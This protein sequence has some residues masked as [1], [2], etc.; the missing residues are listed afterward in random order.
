[1][2]VHRG[3]VVLALAALCLCPG[4]VVSVDAGP[5]TPADPSATAT[6]PAVAP[7]APETARASGAGDAVG[8]APETDTTVVDIEVFENGS[9][10][11]ELRVRTRLRTEADVTEYRRFQEQFR[12]DTESSLDPFR[13][14][15]TGVV[16][17]AAN[18]TGRPMTATA[19]A[20]STRIQEVPRRWGVVAFQFRWEG[21]ANA[22]GDRVAVG[23]AFEGGLFFSENDSLQVTGPAGYEV[24][25]TDPSPD[26]VDG[27]TLTWFGRADFDDRRPRAVFVRPAPT[28]S[29]DRTTTVPGGAGDGTTRRGTEDAT[30]TETATGTPASGDGGSS[31][32]L[33]GLVLVAV[34]GAGALAVGLRRRGRGSLGP[35]GAEPADDAAETDAPAGESETLDDAT[36]AAGAVGSSDLLPDEEKVRRLLADGGGRMKQA[37][38]AEKLDWSAS[39]ASRVLSDMEENGSVEKLR[40]GRENII[41]LVEESSEGD[42]SADDPG[43]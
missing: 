12:N 22:T 36:P 8:V 10:T 29:P 32:L 38:V 13:E 14:R 43:A 31:V 17:S 20:A 35:G 33:G 18:A 5:A 39:K 4:F 28:D 16:E 27:R 21:F 2:S 41:D 24:A 11:W 25:S 1:M 30:T 6:S 26:D 9:A 34:V 7:T 19:F 37:D 3:V 23:D 40:I 15:M 42:G